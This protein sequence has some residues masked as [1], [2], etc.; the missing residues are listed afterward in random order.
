MQISHHE[1]ILKHFDD[2][3]NFPSIFQKFW[4]WQESRIWKDNWNVFDQNFKVWLKHLK[5]IK[6]GEKDSS[7]EKVRGRGS[8]QNM[9]I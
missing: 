3:C 9:Q 4:K 2:E 7:N 5:K 8:L 1:S 6:K